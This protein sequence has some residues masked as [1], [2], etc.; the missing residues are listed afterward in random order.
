MFAPNNGSFTQLK[1][2]DSASLWRYL[3]FTKFVS[4]LDTQTLFFCRADRFADPFE[5]ATTKKTVEHRAK[6]IEELVL[7]HPKI[8]DREDYRRR[9]KILYKNQFHIRKRVA[10]NCWHR[11]EFESEAMWKLYVPSNEGVAI[12]TTVGRL[13]D[14]MSDSEEVIQIAD[15]VYKDYNDIVFSPNNLFTPF[16]TKRKSF[17]HENEVRAYIVKDIG[18]LNNHI[19]LHDTPIDSGISVKVDLTILID[20][21]YIS[22][23]APSWFLMLVKSLLE[24]Y[25]M[26]HVVN[27]SAL[28]EEACF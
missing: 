7:R 12:K 24:K 16:I 13:K 23:T 5:G 25:E 14:A 9:M 8:E 11:N 1:T 26:Q 21:I 22:P 19:E 4:L 18:D 2:Q 10:I 17:E 15:V 20:E 6:Y 27:Q 3:D 28:S